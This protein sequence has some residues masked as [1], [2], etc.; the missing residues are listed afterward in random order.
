MSLGT[1][2]SPAKPISTERAAT[3]LV[4]GRRPSVLQQWGSPQ[5]FSGCAQG[6]AGTVAARIKTPC[7]IPA[8]ESE[9]NYLSLTFEF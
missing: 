7:A 1:E 8:G 3:R 6:S 4:D 9:N 2:S 5:T